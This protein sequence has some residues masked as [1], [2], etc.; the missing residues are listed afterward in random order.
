[1]PER[2]TLRYMGYSTPASTRLLQAS[3][4][5]ATRSLCSPS[6]LG[7]PW[8]GRWQL[9]VVPSKVRPDGQDVQLLAESP[10]Q[11]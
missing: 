7:E 10:W 6:G 8:A 11:V 4:V 3:T 9:W 1:M 2:R 5:T